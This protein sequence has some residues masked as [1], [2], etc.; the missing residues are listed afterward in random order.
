MAR[1]ILLVRLDGL[2]DALV[3]VPAL[4]A[5]REAH[6]DAVFGVVCSEKNAAL[7][8]RARLERIHVLRAG[9]DAVPLIAELRSACYTDALVATEEPIGYRIARSSGATRRAGFWHRFEKP[10][11][12]LWQYG[13][14]TDPVYR[15]A[16]WVAAPEHEVFAI[17]RLAQRLGATA[18]PSTDPNALRPWLDIA[19][20]P[21]ADQRDALVFQVA[22]K[23]TVGGWEPADIAYTLAVAVAASPFRRCVVAAGPSDAELARSV[24]EHVPPASIA[25]GSISSAPPSTLGA[26]LGIIASAGAVVSPD[27]GAAHAAG[28][29]GVPVV[30]IFEAARF[31]QLS[32]QWRP[33]AAPSRCVVKPQRSAGAPAAFGAAIGAALSDLAVMPDAVS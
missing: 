6:E 26:W 8:S 22:E 31:E 19:A 30:D 12:S 33:W 14:L 5:L 15:P 24:M 13:H 9:D 20:V 25:E 11:K 32:R 28:M 7:F 18:P 2:G 10:F 29:L 21:V 3:C 4:E 1:N 17:H 27:T 23:W 16:A